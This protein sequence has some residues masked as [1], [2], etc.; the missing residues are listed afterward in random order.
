MLNPNPNYVEFP[1]PFGVHV[2]KFHIRL[3]NT[4]SYCVSVPF[5]GSCSEIPQLAIPDFTRLQDV[6]CGADCFFVSFLRRFFEKMR[7]KPCHC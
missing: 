6:V 3:V 2:L 7:F 5:R 1:S 4:I